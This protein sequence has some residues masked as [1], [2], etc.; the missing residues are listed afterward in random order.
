[1]DFIK[2][3]M[4]YLKRKR[5]RTIILFLLL[6]VIAS[7]LLVS[8]AI[9][10]STNITMKNLRNSMGG[11][12]KI[13]TNTAQGYRDYVT[14]ELVESIKESGEIKAF[15]GMDTLYALVKDAALV[16]GRF[17]LAGDE[18]AH[19]ARVIG[20]TFSDYNEYFSLKSL[21]LVE[22]ESL[23][24]DDLGK[25]LISE[26][27]AQANGL[28][29]GDTITIRFYVADA[30]EEEESR[31]NDQV[32]EIAGI[33]RVERTQNEQ[34]STTAECDIVE[35][36]IFA[37]TDSF[38]D[39]IYDATGN[40]ID[41]YTSGAVFYVNDPKNLDKITAN[42]AETLNQDGER[43]LFTKN[44]KTYEE[45]AVILERLNGMMTAMIL[46]F[47]VISAAI[48]SLLLILLMRDR[49]HEI[50]IFVSMGV[51]KFKIFGQHVFEN[52]I[53]A[54]CALCVACV[55]VSFSTSAISGAVNNTMQ[56]GEETKTETQ[57]P[58]STTTVE[59][60]PEEIDMDISIGVMEFAEILGMELLIV[61]I[62]TGVSFTLVIRM[63]PKDILSLTS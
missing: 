4:L 6:T 42:L 39:I 31:I 48:L 18:K 47:F 1:M 61:I 46:A 10:N 38:R 36:F 32:L 21:V 49:L 50:G 20:T 41:N 15:D 51:K 27:L 58:G 37:N 60:V 54:I 52:A 9:W 24:A 40:V 14:D 19:L 12:F 28:S 33:Y 34:D 13:E 23:Q 59:A 55:L 30:T 63:K 57:L 16:P 8:A 2:R 56:S 25:A 22:G 53:V 43:Y 11:Y 29:V 35:N 5:S 7:L 26:D 45:T 3:G 62:S 44:N 17:T